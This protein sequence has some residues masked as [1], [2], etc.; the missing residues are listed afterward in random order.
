MVSK[1][2]AKNFWLYS[3][4]DIHQFQ[5]FMTDYYSLSQNSSGNNTS[6]GQ[7]LE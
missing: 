4:N 3:K 2:R 6:H 5:W 7:L 1:L